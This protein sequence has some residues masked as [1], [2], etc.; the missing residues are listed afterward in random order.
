MDFLKLLVISIA[1]FAI[2]KFVIHY[3][4]IEEN[5]NEMNDEDHLDQI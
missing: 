5:L 1:V 3:S 4:K 2:G